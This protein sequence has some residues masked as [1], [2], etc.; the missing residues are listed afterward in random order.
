MFYKVQNNPLIHFKLV[1]GD[2]VIFSDSDSNDFNRKAK[3]SV[4]HKY[5]QV[6]SLKLKVTGLDEIT[7][8]NEIKTIS[9]QVFVIITTQDGEQEIQIADQKLEVL[10]KSKFKRKVQLSEKDIVADLKASI[11]DEWND[12][13]ADALSSLYELE[14]S[15][16]L[17]GKPLLTTAIPSSGQ[18]V[19]SH[20][21]SEYAVGRKDSS[22][23]NAFL[24]NIAQSQ[25]TKIFVAVVLIFAIFQMVISVTGNAIEVKNKKM[26][27]EIFNTLGQSGSEDEAVNRVLK[28]MGIERS[29]DKNDLGCFVE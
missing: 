27:G 8:K 10:Q 16:A 20:G 18:Y 13:F 14:R 24:S 2:L 17:P 15:Q 7:E 26:E 12:V 9:G 25:W 19:V 4:H 23:I 28:E 5:D 11:I 1:N 22:A 3:V 29:S 21:P 6:Q